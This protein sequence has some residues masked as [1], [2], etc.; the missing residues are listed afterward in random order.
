[1]ATIEMSRGHKLGTEEAKKRAIQV[2]DR[3][4]E[5]GIKGTWNGNTF[6]I[7]APAKGTFVV[8]DTDVKISLDLP[9][10]LRPLKGKIESKITQEFDR[11]LV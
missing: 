6:D 4:K 2:L 1:M 8:S 9:F 10:M 7:T 3:M 11:V 5:Y